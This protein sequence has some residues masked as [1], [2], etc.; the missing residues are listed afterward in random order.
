M[1]LNLSEEMVL[2]KDRQKSDGY[3]WLCTGCRDGTTPPSLSVRASSLF[4]GKHLSFLSFLLLAERWANH[5]GDSGAKVAADVG[6]NQET[7]VEHYELFRDVCSLWIEHHS[8][9]TKIGGPGEVVEID[10]SHFYPRKYNRGRWHRATWIFGGIQRGS[11]NVFMVPVER[12]DWATLSEIIYAN[13]ADDSIIMTDGYFRLNDTAQSYVHYYVNH[14]FN[15]VNPEDDTIHTQSIE[16][17]WGSL[18]RSLKHLAGI[19][20]NMFQ[21][22]LDNYVFRRAH[23]NQDIL[24]NFLFWMIIFYEPQP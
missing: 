16:A 1:I 13:V 12:R 9:V 4:A 5:P 2:R 23:N 18:K 19:R 8:S 22:Y 24:Q 11:R 21:G 15:F 14:K 6:V 3:K 20:K 17:T 7:V 10:E